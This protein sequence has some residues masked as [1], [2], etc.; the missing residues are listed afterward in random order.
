MFGEIF[1]GGRQIL[2]H[3]LRLK[4]GSREQVKIQQHLDPKALNFQDNVSI[5]FALDAT[6]SLLIDEDRK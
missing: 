2:H 6:V 5:H 4:I 1:C 3:G